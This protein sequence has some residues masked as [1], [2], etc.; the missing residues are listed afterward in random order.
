[1]TV[2]GEDWKPDLQDPEVQKYLYEEAGE[3]A[4]EM[5]MFIEE[6]QPISGV[7]ILEHYEERKPS[8]VRKILY[9]LMEAHAAEYE[10]DTD[11]KGWETFTW[12]LDLPEVA[13]IL[14]RRW[15]DELDHLRK[16]IGFEKDHEF[17]ACKH[18]HRRMLFEDSMDL[19]FQC[20]VC[21]EPMEPLD[22]RP[23]VKALQ[24]RIDELSEVIEA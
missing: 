17:Y 23:V 16:Q 2:H 1:M 18:L 12:Q 5:A 14:R 24:E 8:D 20:P 3:E 6:H 10:K 11:S 22:N 15:A 4:L 21:D 9:R 13:L 19:G 7:E